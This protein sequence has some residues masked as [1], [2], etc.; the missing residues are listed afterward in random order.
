[1]KQ[2]FASK[3]LMKTK[4]GTKFTN[5]LMREGK[6]TQAEKLLRKTLSILGAKHIH[7][8]WLALKNVRPLIEVRTIRVR[9]AN[10]Q[11]PIPVNSKRSTSLAIKWLINSAR[12]K[13]GMSTAY[14]LTDEILLASE[15]RGEAYKRKLQIHKTAVDNRAYQHFRWY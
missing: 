7:L 12:K 4:F 15:R 8:L 10:H 2:L 6:K 3:E 11:V 13:K 14:L 5:C 1:M 9:G